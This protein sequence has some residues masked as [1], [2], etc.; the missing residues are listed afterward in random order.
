MK[1]NS[2]GGS[3]HANGIFWEKVST[4]HLVLSHIY[5]MFLIFEPLIYSLIHCFE[6]V[7]TLD[8]DFRN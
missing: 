7:N 2:F 4:D 5:T 3:F 8:T 6:H 1:P